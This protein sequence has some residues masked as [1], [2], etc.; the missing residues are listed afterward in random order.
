MKQIKTSKGEFIFVECPKEAYDFR[1]KNMPDN[2][3]EFVATIENNLFNIGTYYFN[4]LS[5]AKF[6]YEF[7]CTTDTITEEIAKEIVDDN[8]LGCYNNYIFEDEKYTW[9]FALD[10]FYCLL[11]SNNLISS[12]KIYAIC[13]RLK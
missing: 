6:K 12:S 2:S 9:N 5:G 8:G 3:I 7:I 11:Q 13:K 1:S 4:E 10:S